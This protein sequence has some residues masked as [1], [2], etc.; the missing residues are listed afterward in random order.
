M[1]KKQAII[2]L[3]SSI[4]IGF[5]AIQPFNYIC[6]LTDWCE[7]ISISYYLPKKTGNKMFDVVFEAKDLSEN[8]NFRNLTRS[9]V[10]LSGSDFELKYEARNKSG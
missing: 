7:P 10:I 1:S 9:A 5:L 2:L 8:V 4:L 6:R 3:T